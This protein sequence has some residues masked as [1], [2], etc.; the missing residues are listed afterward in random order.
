MVKLDFNGLGA[1]GLANPNRGAKLH[2]E[3]SVQCTK[4]D[5]SEF[6]GLH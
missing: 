4:A 1:S 5:S 2:L 3:E 6:D